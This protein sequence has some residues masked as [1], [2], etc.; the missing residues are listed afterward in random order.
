MPWRQIRLQIQNEEF[1]WGCD[2]YLKHGEMMPDTILDIL[3]GLTLSSWAV[4]ACQQGARPIS[5]ILHS[6]PKGL[7]SMNLGPSSSIRALKLHQTASPES[8]HGVVRENTEEYAGVGGFFKPGTPDAF[9]VQS[10]LF[11]YKGCERVMRYAFELARKRKKLGGKPPVGMVT[12]CTKSNALNY[13]MVF[14]DSVYRE[15]ARRYP[16][17]KT[18]KRWWMRPPYGS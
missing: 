7:I 11:T 6:P 18:D 3:K 4:S 2:Y 8:R 5:L 10:A 9:A 14:W 15:V 16:D 1:D 12:N 13:S 17:V